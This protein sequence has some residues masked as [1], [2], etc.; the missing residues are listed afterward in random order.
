LNW[1]PGETA[2]KDELPVDLWV[3]YRSG[4]G[5]REPDCQWDPYIEWWRND[6][7]DRIPKSATV[8]YWVRVS[9]PE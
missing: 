4:N 5:T 8:K 3:T 9:D 7:G 1:G 2:P 6:H